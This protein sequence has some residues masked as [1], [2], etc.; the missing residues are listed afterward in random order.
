[1]NYSISFLTRAEREFLALPKSDSERVKA[2]I[3]GLAENPR[4]VNCK[5]LKGR[6]GWRLRAGKYRVVY[7]IDDSIRS[8]TVINV[9]HR[10]EVYR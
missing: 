6:A 7:E 8:V 5:K 9:G 4:P 1:V 3:E 10:R 2:A